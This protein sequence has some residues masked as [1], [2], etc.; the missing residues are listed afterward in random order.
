MTTLITYGSSG[1]DKGRCD[2]K[3]YGAKRADCN[4][5]CGGANHGKGLAVASE[6]TAKLAKKWIDDYEAKH[7]GEEVI[8]KTTYDQ[9]VLFGDHDSIQ[10]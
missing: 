8:A 2:A 3:C 4:C 6:Q 7:P 1:G 9:G 10:V 5:I